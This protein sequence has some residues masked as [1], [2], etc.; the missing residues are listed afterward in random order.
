MRDKTLIR[1]DGCLSEIPGE[2]ARVRD[3]L[4]GQRHLCKRCVA[5]GLSIAP[6]GAIDIV[7]T[8]YRGDQF[9]ASEVR[10]MLRDANST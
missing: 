3:T 2:P 7:V 4:A 6:S 5:A 8:G 9:T 1:C 10:Q